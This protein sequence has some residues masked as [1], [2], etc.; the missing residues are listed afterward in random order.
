MSWDEWF[1]SI[2]SIVARKSKDPSTKVGCIVVGDDHEI[3]ATGYNGFPRGSNDSLEI[4]NNRPRKYL[5]V[6]HAEANAV[7]NASFTGTSLKGGTAYITHP[8]CA[9]CSGLLVNAGV[10]HVK[11]IIDLHAVDFNDRWK[12]QFNEGISIFEEVGIDFIAYSGCW[13]VNSKDCYSLGVK[14]KLDE[15]RR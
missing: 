4:Y 9:S 12:E 11:F 13:D 7:A 5:R 6:V 8:P 14:R 1:F 2:A 3:R 10:Y 15:L